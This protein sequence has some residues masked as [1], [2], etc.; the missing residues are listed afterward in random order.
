MYNEIIIINNFDD[1]R[2]YEI[3]IEGANSIGK[4]INYLSLRAS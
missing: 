4:N 3:N 1:Q 2:I